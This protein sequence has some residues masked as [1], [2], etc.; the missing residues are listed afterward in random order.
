MDFTTPK[1]NTSYPSIGFLTTP[2]VEIAT[3]SDDYYNTI[4][5]GE[6]EYDGYEDP[7]QSETVTISPSDEHS[8]EEEEIV[9]LPDY[10]P[11]YEDDHTT[12]PPHPEFNPVYEDQNQHIATEH[13]TKKTL[14][15]PEYDSDISYPYSDNVDDEIE[16]NDLYNDCS[17]GENYIDYFSRR[18]CISRRRH[19]NK[20]KRRKNKI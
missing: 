4:E 17:R 12:N 18:P 11:N 15:G 6:V 8:Q 7:S 5:Y 1:I 13:T 2:K 19:N 10:N 16:G 3:D 14:S 9:T 20:N